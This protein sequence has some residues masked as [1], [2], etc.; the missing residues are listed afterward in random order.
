M[1]YRYYEQGACFYLNDLG[2]IFTV[3]VNG[4]SL[5]YYSKDTRL[6][7]PVRQL[8]ES[9]TESLE[10]IDK[11][12]L[13]VVLNEITQKEIKLHISEYLKG[14]APLEADCKLA[15]ALKLQG[16]VG[17]SINRKASVS[18]KDK[19]K[20]LRKGDQNTLL[21]QYAALDANHVRFDDM[22]MKGRI[23]V[24]GRT[25]TPN[26]ILMGIRS[27][28]IRD[29]VRKPDMDSDI[30][31]S[32]PDK[33]LAIIVFRLRLGSNDAKEVLRLIDSKLK[34]LIR[35]RQSLNASGY[36]YI[37]VW[38]FESDDCE[39]V[40]L[41]SCFANILQYIRAVNSLKVEYGCN[42]ELTYGY[43]HTAFIALQTAKS[44]FERKN[45]QSVFDSESYSGLEEAN[46][47]KYSDAQEGFLKTFL[48]H[49][50]RFEK[51]VTSRMIKNGFT[52]RSASTQSMN[53]LKEAYELDNRE[54]AIIYT[55]LNSKR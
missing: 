31:L 12:S 42:V 36:S 25:E 13:D 38:V 40:E 37:P 53:Q 54:A 48:L 22:Y 3:R 7:A 18:A 20:R 49:V 17:F 14:K 45:V 15:K 26:A 29:I 39:I 35:R 4:G 1:N 50:C 41:E 43:K 11:N 2:S 33:K 21:D 32:Y 46:S 23:N 34:S 24:I 28:G 10:F 52:I 55:A 30:E 19:L 16:K 6:V 27:T 8:I 44:F 51:S 5:V 47:L 9:Y